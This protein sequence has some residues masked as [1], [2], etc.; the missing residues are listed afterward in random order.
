MDTTTIS[1]I[2]AVA[3]VI[4][5]L[6]ALINNRLREKERDMK[7]NNKQDNEITEIKGRVTVLE[8]EQKEIKT[9]HSAM[10]EKLYT[11]IDRL[12]EKIDDFIRAIAAK[13]Q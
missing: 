10:E 9:S 8:R 11:K 2:A 3:G 13:P 6:S 4:F 12:N 5:G 7:E 1:I